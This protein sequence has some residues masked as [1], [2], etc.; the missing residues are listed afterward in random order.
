MTIDSLPAPLHN[1]FKS[2]ERCVEELYQPAWLLS[3]LDDEKWIVGSTADVRSVAGVIKGGIRISWRK[4]LPSGTLT[5]P[6]YALVLEQSKLILVWAFDGALPKLIGSLRTFASFHAFLFRLTEYL[7]Y[8]Y[9]TAFRE[10][11]FGVLTV[12]D[13][14]DF[15]ERTIESGVCGTGFFIER[16]L[17]S[18]AK[19]IS[20]DASRAEVVSYLLRCNAFE[21]PGK[22]SLV[23][24]GD[25]IGVDANRLA[26]S[27]TFKSYISMYARNSVEYEK[28]SVTDKTVTQI[29]DWFV[30]FAQVVASLP[31]AS[32]P[33]FDD[34]AL[35]SG[36]LRGYRGISIGRTKTMPR[37][38]A[39]Q[40]IGQVCKWMA[41]VAPP[42]EIYISDIVRAA[43]VLREDTPLL[44]SFAAIRSAELQVPVPSKLIEVKSFY[45]KIQEG[46]P[47]D[48]PLAAPISLKMVRLHAGVCFVLIALLSCSRRSEVME[49]HLEDLQYKSG[50]GY[51]Q[52]FL[53]KTGCNSSRRKILK[54]IPGIVGDSV[55]SLGRLKISL[56]RLFECKDALLLDRVFFKTSQFG[57]GPMISGD[58]YIPLRELSKFLQL[59][60][61]SGN[62]WIVRPHQ[63]RRYF[64]LS[65]FHDSG[66]ENSL[67]ALSW[68]MGHADIEGTWRYVKESLTGREITA[69]EAA[70]ATSAVCSDDESDGAVKLRKLLFE[71]FGCSNIS[72]M[73]EDSIQDYLQLLAEEGVFTATPVQVI[74]GKQ[75]RISVLISIKEKEHAAT[76]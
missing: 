42:L 7:D 65:F 18:I 74:W 66:A 26:G 76:I 29:V 53:R 22:I 72:L 13:I 44:N 61:H 67:P 60:D 2:T 9:Q 48:H 14:L 10:K 1:F 24:V 25:S 23:F 51:L 43:C 54:P 52:I 12:E 16:W 69:A 20:A 6:K 8:K 58:I 70:M 55:A 62:E 36:L 35:L 37:S 59:K 47:I 30:S 45:E 21:K 27:D 11:A 63:L 28:V 15:L 19:N 75:K 50:L 5:D 38:V 46:K 64:A 40:L 49:L 39:R 34:P 17:E 4:K 41:E 32:S 31:I 73:D 68:F 57:L 3:A 56:M 33:E 71:H